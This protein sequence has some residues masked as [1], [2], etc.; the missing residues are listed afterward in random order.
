M[1]PLQRLD[2]AMGV[3][4]RQG[5]GSKAESDRGKVLR[6]Y[7]WEQFK[8]KEEITEF[9]EA[10]FSCE[11]T[12]QQN[13]S[14]G[15]KD[16]QDR[17]RVIH[18]KKEGM[19]KAA[20]ATTLGRS[21]KF[22]AKW[23]QKEVKEVPRPWGVHDYLTKD[24]GRKSTGVGATNGATMVEDSANDT[25]TW[26]RDVEVRRKF[27]D[28]PAIYS[29]LLQNTEWKPSNART[30]DFATG[31]YHLKYDQ[32]GNIKWEGHQGGKYKQGLS[33][34]T[35]KVM[36]KL[37]AEYGI[38]DR[39][40]GVITNWYP[41]G[42]GNLGS[43]RHDCWT[44]LF[45]FGTERILTIDNT[46]L[47]MQDG[48]L[49]IFGTQRHG[50]PRMPE[51]TEGRIT[52][53]V[54]FYPNKMQKQGMWQT[55]TDPETMEASK[56]LVT[57]LQDRQLGAD[58]EKREIEASHGK[59]LLALQQLGFGRADAEAALRASRFDVQQAAEFLLLSGAGS[60][61]NDSHHDQN[62]QHLLVGDSVGSG[63]SQDTAA[64]AG[65][66][67]VCAT[68]AGN[69][70]VATSA[71]SRGGRFKKYGRVVADGVAASTLAEPP[72][73]DGC[74]VISHA[75]RDTGDKSVSASCCASV[76]ATSS[77]STACSS[78]DRTVSSSSS[79][80]GS[81]S[82]APSS[83]EAIASLKMSGAASGLVDTDE[84]AAS[85]ALALQLQ[86]L[87]RPA[88]A[89]P[90][91]LAAQ[92]QEYEKMLTMDDAEDWNGSGDLM[93]SP[94]AREQLS[95]EKMEKVTV[96]SVGH[97]DML[98]KDFWEMLSCHSIRVLYDVRPT[99]YRGELF[100]R[101]QRFTVAALRAQCRS[102]GVVYKP[103]PLGRES[104]YG[105]LAHIKT[106]EGRHTLTEIV[107]QAKRRRT[108]F[109]GREE[110]WRDD[111]R[112]VAAEELTQ[113][114]HTV[115][116]VRTDG[117]TE[118]HCRVASFPDWLLREEERLK[119]VEKKRQAS[120]VVRPQK[121]SVDRSTE[122]IASRLT[123][124]VEEVD[125]MKEMRNAANQRELVVA[126]RK[127]ARY[128]RIAEEKGALAGKVLKGTPEWILEDAR[129][130]AEWVTSKKK[131]KDDREAAE[132]SGRPPPLA[133]TAS[134]T[135]GK[136]VEEASSPVAV[137]SAA[138]ART[139]VA[140]STSAPAEEETD[141]DFAAAMAASAAAEAELEEMS[142]AAALAAVAEAVAKDEA[143]GAGVVGE[144][145]ENGAKRDAVTPLVSTWRSRRRAAAET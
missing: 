5:E 125:A 47:L 2:E 129:K 39:T 138:A 45:S 92:F 68:A 132:A 86:E 44:A 124:P 93:H 80:A 30:R 133:S 15:H 27:V 136:Q 7:R 10:H 99:D 78:T 96:Y 23:W 6:V 76:T 21:E 143:E 122:S 131:E 121:S 135:G 43:H 118:T 127:L 144:A 41:D 81:A 24:M 37:F 113:A 67:S 58:A 18:L 49:A 31:A 103:M 134:G 87:D 104:A 59:E 63:A 25:A 74:D 107:W 11:G 94:F 14:V 8:G 60:V 130:Q 34:A 36:Q 73:S 56:P 50:V 19:D 64:D 100:E 105:M 137:A 141:G 112:Q 142:A 75:S 28:D 22:V 12:F 98:E 65:A 109:M 85:L 33:P 101:H 83:A 128:Q 90:S 145:R 70:P 116:H 123:R 88:G 40:S 66:I 95:I 69:V 35:D 114:G 38:A 72:P 117:S 77:A 111:P 52:L 9:D 97:G 29:E 48:D 16:Y 115:E 62:M 84:E 42:D 139:I 140:L 53:V 102:R 91:L 89:D 17:L 126:Q 1:P 3:R 13:S 4:R 71:V 46:P 26:W 20:I 79:S 108:A 51:I 32:R 120:E 119:K 110:S 55:I 54:F 82:T 106:D 57:M 61:F